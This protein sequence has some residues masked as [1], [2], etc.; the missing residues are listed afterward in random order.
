[1]PRMEMDISQNQPCG[2]LPVDKPEGPTSHDVV[3]R[4]RKAFGIRQVGHTGT[5][6]P[7]ASGL[8]ILCIGRATRLSEYILHQD[9]TYIFELAL[10][11]ISDTGD[12]TGRITDFSDGRQA[13]DV[14]EREILETLIAFTGEIEQTP[15]LFSALKV[16][17]KK[18]YELARAGSHIIPAP[19]RVIIHSL[20]LVR[21]SPPGLL[22]EARVGAGTYIRSL[23]RD[24]GQRLNTGAYV[25]MLR[26]TAIGHLG[27]EGAL[28]PD[29]L[30]L[31]P[32]TA[33]LHLLSIPDALPSWRRVV[34][35]GASEER[36]KNGAAVSWE[37]GPVPENE[38]PFL[39]MNPSGDVICVAVLK[40]SLIQPIKVLK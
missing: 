30:E 35:A 16:G 3:A 39:V 32:A 8:L 31:H 22:L 26:R 6:D 12:P 20:R 36:L 23:G 5:L 18:L 10:G 7:F 11:L 34:L 38:G 4:V 15:P 19:R 28:P 9:K 25:R 2:F 33:L 40:K 29:T 21:F 1:M 37:E 27:V 24:I 17:G 13:D 14:S